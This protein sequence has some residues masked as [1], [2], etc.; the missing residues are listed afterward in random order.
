MVLCLCLWGKKKNPCSEFEPVLLYT[1]AINEVHK[2]FQTLNILL[3]FKISSICWNHGNTGV[4]WYMYCI[5]L[6]LKL[7]TQLEC[8]L[9]HE[10]FAF[11]PAF[12]LNLQTIHT[13]SIG[14]VF[15]YVLVYVYKKNYP[16]VWVD[17]CWGVD[18]K[19]KK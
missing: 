6:N 15:I 13:Y 7:Q 16:P 9:K 10:W 1:K 12:N 8:T 3:V 19:D 17:S 4:Y 5:C 11:S 2:V 14:Q 18:L